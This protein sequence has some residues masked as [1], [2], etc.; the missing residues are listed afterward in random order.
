MMPAIKKRNLEV[1][2]TPLPDA[3]GLLD[4][5]ISPIYREETTTAYDTNTWAS[6]WIGPVWQRT[7]ISGI[8]VHIDN[9]NNIYRKEFIF[10]KTII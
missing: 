5:Y 3:D 7:D 10:K 6:L 9:T 4:L 2:A 8:R 1:T